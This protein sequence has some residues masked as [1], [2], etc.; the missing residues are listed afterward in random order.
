ME[1][2]FSPGRKLGWNGGDAPLNLPRSQPRTR[3]THNAWLALGRC[4]HCWPST[5][6]PGL[7]HSPQA[8]IFHPKC[9]EPESPRVSTRLLEGVCIFFDETVNHGLPEVHILTF[10]IYFTGPAL[11]CLADLYLSFKVHLQA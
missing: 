1:F 9:S 10:S 3:I 4:S 7:G 11:L 6:T 2:W 5:P 8:W